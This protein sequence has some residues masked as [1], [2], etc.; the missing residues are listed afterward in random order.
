MDP[1]AFKEQINN[2]VPSEFPES[3]LYGHSNLFFALD[4]YRDLLGSYVYPSPEPGALARTTNDEIDS[5][6]YANLNMTIRSK[7]ADV[8]VVE[9]IDR[10]FMI[11]LS[12]QLFGGIGVYG[13]TKFRSKQW[14]MLHLD[15]R[16]LGQGHSKETALIWMRIKGKY[17]Y[18]QYEEYGEVLLFNFLMN[19]SK[20]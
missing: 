18:P 9:R 15:I 7:A 11:A 5:T 10:A 14:P 19:Q 20:R 8:F 6:H 2:F 1:K 13:D 17:I 4:K 3:V 12:S 16:P